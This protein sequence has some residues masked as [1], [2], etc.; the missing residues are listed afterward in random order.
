MTGVERAFLNTNIERLDGHSAAEKITLCATIIDIPR[1]VMVVPLLENGME[2]CC[3]GFPACCFG[4]PGCQVLKLKNDLRYEVK[5]YPSYS[6]VLTHIVGMNKEDAIECGVVDTLRVCLD[7]SAE[8]MGLYDAIMT[9]NE[10]S[11]NS[12]VNKEDIYED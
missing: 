10:T 11:K 4:F 1:G 12:R 8:T 5:L 6:D 9:L 3:F 7:R 2:A